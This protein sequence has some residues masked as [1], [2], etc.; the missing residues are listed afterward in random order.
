MAK[1]SAELIVISKT[2]DLV[3]WGSTHIEKFPRTHRFTLGDRLE[4]RLYRVLEL[5]IRAKYRRDR[6]ELLGEA[7]LE[8]ELLRYQFRMAKDLRCLSIDSY[9][10]AARAVNE[11]GSLVGG[12]MKAS[13]RAAG[14]GRADEAAR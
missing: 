2:Y 10:Y 4:L 1:A 12:W 7:N 11:I 3:I 6:L 9:G 5:L 14:S 8:L 13:A